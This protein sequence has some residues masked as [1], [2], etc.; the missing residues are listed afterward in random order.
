MSALAVAQSRR[1]RAQPLATVEEA[2]DVGDL[3]SVHPLDLTMQLLGA[4]DDPDTGVLEQ[5]ELKHLVE[6]HRRSDYL[7]VRDPAAVDFSF[8]LS[9]RLPP[10]MRGARAGR[11]S[12]SG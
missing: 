3:A 1:G 2:R 8:R 7:G 6:P 5:R 11:R 10:I 12:Q 9:G 4:H